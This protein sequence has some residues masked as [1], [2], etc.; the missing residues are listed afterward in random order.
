MALLL[1]YPYE[2]HATLTSIF[3]HL[4]GNLDEFV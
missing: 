2:V 1:V 4:Y 3:V